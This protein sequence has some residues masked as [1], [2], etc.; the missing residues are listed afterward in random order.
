MSVHPPSLAVFAVDVEFIARDIQT[1]YFVDY[2]SLFSHIFLLFNLCPPR[3]L[4][5]HV[6]I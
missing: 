4:F 3:S 2:F 6:A 5:P 1:V